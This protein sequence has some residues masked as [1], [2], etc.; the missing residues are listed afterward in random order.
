MI[1]PYAVVDQDGTYYITEDL[2]GTQVVVLEVK[3]SRWTPSRWTP[4]P[5]GVA[6]HRLAALLNAGYTALE[7]NP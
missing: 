6:A 3:T 2:T 5:D 7:G 4:S 1:A